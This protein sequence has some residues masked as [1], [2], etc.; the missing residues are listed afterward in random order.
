MF[1]R[2]PYPRARKWAKASAIQFVLFP[3]VIAAIIVAVTTVDGSGTRCRSSSATCSAGGV[4]SPM[5]KEALLDA[6]CAKSDTGG[7]GNEIAQGCRATEIAGSF[8]CRWCPA[9]GTASWWASSGT[10]CATA[11]DNNHNAMSYGDINI[12]IGGDLCSHG[13]QCNSKVCRGCAAT[14]QLRSQGITAPCTG[15][16]GDGFCCGSKGN[17]MGCT[18]C[19]LDGDCSSCSSGYYL[20][21]AG[22]EAKCFRADRPN[23]AECT[24]SSQ[25]TSGFCRGN[26]RGEK[27]GESLLCGVFRGGV[28]GCFKTNSKFKCTFW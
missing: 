28:K 13:D 16:N 5:D 15:T 4:V 23:G 3:L 27:D 1:C 18:A 2:S 9:Q 10:C 12:G 20:G 24:S 11:Y 22:K 25:C 19:G 8:P 14:A 21:W 7:S 26:E 17:S 6:G